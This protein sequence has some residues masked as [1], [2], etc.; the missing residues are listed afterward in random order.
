ML[1]LALDGGVEGWTVDLDRLDDA[2]EL[3]AAV[4]REH[5]PDLASPSTP[6]GA[7][8]SPAQPALPER[9]IRRR[10]PAPPSIWSSSRCCSTPAPGPAGAIADAA[11]GRTFA[12]SE[13]LAVASQRMFEAGA[14]SPIRDAAARRRRGPGRA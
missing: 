11:S 10:A 4:T 9:P 6:A 1:D 7:I 2:A 5:Y 14:F 8:S 13:G 3:T 12:R